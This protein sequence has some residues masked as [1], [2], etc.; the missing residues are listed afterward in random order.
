M[1]IEHVILEKAERIR[2]QLRT[3]FILKVELKKCYNFTSREAPNS[4]SRLRLTKSKASNMLMS[5]RF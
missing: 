2:F 1:G 5:N 3:S 4:A